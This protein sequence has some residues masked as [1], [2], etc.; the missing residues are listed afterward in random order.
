ME[1]RLLTP[2]RNDRLNPVALSFFAGLIGFVYLMGIG[3]GLLLVW[4][5]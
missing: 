4:P 5:K 2:T 1:K 3:L